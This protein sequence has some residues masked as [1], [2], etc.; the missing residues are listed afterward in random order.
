M[1][2]EFTFFAVAPRGA[3]SLLAEEVAEILSLPVKQT[4]AG[5]NFQ[6]NLKQAYHLALHSRLASRLLVQIAQLKVEAIEG[7]YAAMQEIAWSTHFRSDQSITIKFSGR[8]RGVD[9]NTFG[10]MRVKDAIADQFYRANG[11]RPSVD[12]IDP[13][14][15]I[16]VHCYKGQCEVSLDFTGPLNQRGYRQGQGQAPLKENFAAALVI[17]SGVV[18]ADPKL[19][20]DPM[21]G[22]G[23][24]LIEAAMQRLALPAGAHKR[25]WAFTEWRGHDEELW[26]QAQSAAQTDYEEKIAAAKQAVVY[27]G[28]KYR[29]SEID[30]AI[31]EQARENVAAAGLSTLIE[32]R[33]EDC[34]NAEI[35]VEEPGFLLSNLPYGERV[36]DKAD[37][38]A[39]YQRLGEA[40]KNQLRSWQ[41]ALLVE[42]GALLE[43]SIAFR[44]QKKYKFFNGA[45]PVV[46]M[47]YTLDES[48]VFERFDPYW[49][50][51]NWE[52]QL[53]PG[54]TMLKNR[55]Q[56][57]QQRLKKW[58]KAG[59]ITCYRL[60]DADLP[61]Y[62]AAIDIYEGHCHIQEYQAP[63]SIE[64]A[65]AEH[66]L[67]ELIHVC[68]GLF[69]GD[70][71][72]I[73]V[74]VRRRQSGKQQ[75][76][77]QG[78]NSSEQKKHRRVVHEGGLK[79]H[80][81]L[82]NYLD[83]GLFLDH[84][85]ARQWV[86]EN[87]RGKRFLNLFA[88]TGSVSVYAAA[89][90]AKTT[91]TIDLSQTYLDWAR[92]NMQLNG[93][94]GASHRYIQSDCLNW[95]R[96]NR[97]QYDLIFLDPP[98]FS[99]SKKTQEDFDVQSDHEELIRLCM[100]AVTRDGCLF[101]SNNFR[102]FK[103]AE[104]ITKSF[105]VEEISHKTIAEDFKRNKRI[106][107]SWLVKHS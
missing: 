54:A 87:A 49:V 1:Q 107:R 28:L 10:A 29:G 19:V 39:L 62:A 89:G 105:S 90:G 40:M 82:V 93:Y 7:L 48:N 14:V 71:E 34:F 4:K 24:L 70:K 52:S 83:T 21:C 72:T 59:D 13:D 20:W 104:S 65:V 8:L 44:W 78:Q 55:L 6:A 3:E 91:T 45:L 99:N 98:T 80:V 86:R 100:K 31:A 11:E 92:D 60:Y 22:S 58:L 64:A 12:K 5:V 97:Q 77:K 73:A 85:S 101:F 23:T 33:T 76:Q 15:S 35:D 26:R 53:S 57:N 84:R 2:P 18:K 25:F 16:Q 74:K 9:N 63:K 68:A 37:L 56:K 46:L 75:Y 30:P 17:R 42:D 94:S 43:K 47:T 102:Q 67:N 38:K 95:L 27:R 32:I 50:G 96:E 61:E 79:F 41:V 51:P 103:L 88:Y 106:H 69:D 66:R 36:S 81:D